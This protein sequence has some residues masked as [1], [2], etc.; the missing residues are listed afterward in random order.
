MQMFSFPR[1]LAVVAI[2]A[3]SACSSNKKVAGVPSVLPHVGLHGSTSTPAHNMPA[4]E[5]PFDANGNYV[6]SWAAAGGGAAA[7][8]Y[9]SWR[10]SH[11]GGSSSSSA[12]R[13]SGSGSTKKKTSSS[14]AKKKPVSRTVRH[15]VKK[16]D[17]L[18]GIAS[19][20]GSSVSRI[21]AANGLK[22]DMIR[23]GRTLT[24]PR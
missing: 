11:S 20:Y 18:S 21:K 9:S 8:D 1:F 2:A 13:S 15:T 10:S 22:S 7:T 4:T 5:Y 12:R 23:D 16:G 17:T 14:S 19:R 3:L 6:Q 24:I